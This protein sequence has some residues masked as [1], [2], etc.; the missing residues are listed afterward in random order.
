[1]ESRDEGK[2]E[3]AFRAFGQKVDEFVKELNEASEKIR[4]EFEEKYEE[5]KE[6]AEKLKREAGNKDRWEQAETSLKKA[7][8]ELAKAFKAAFGKR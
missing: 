2:S 3:K 6:S 4:K 5:L 1:M 7:A 8:D